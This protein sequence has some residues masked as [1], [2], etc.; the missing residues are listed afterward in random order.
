MIMTQQTRTCPRCSKQML[1]RR[2]G[3][4][5]LS[6]PPQYPTRWRCGCGHSEPVPTERGIT[7]TESF[8]RDWLA[9]NAVSP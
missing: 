4:A 6:S 2:T 7:P 9:A 8:N 3:E 1:L 5:L